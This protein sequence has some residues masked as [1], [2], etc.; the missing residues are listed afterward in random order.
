MGRPGESSAALAARRKAHT[1]IPKR[2]AWEM[3]SALMDKYDGV[4]EFVDYR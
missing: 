2:E 3:R 1:V 4:V